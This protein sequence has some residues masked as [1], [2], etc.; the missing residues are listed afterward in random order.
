VTRRQGALVAL[1]A[2][3]A[4]GAWHALRHVTLDSDYSA[5]LP[6]GT[7]DTQRALMRE[8]REGLR[9]RV[10]LIALGGAPQPELAQASR[11]L[12]AALEQ[13][14][15]FRYANNGSAISGSASSR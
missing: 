1:A 14:P 13:S 15:A 11:K 10:V 7:S 6:A 8:L 9:S 4:A 5:F 3:V 2:L 12:V